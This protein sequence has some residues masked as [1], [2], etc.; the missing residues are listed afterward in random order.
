MASASENL[1]VRQHERIE[2]Q[3]AGGVR[4]AP[5]QNQAIRIASNVVDA[6]NCVP[7]SVRDCSMGGVGLHTGVFLPKRSQLTLVLA[8]GTDPDQ[9][10]ALDLKVMRVVMLD[11][12]P[13]YYLGAALVR[14][15]DEASR[16]MLERLVS[17][18]R[19]QAQARTAVLQ[20]GTPLA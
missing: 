4:V 5:A 8:I 13:T 2:C 18:A 19:A 14:P 12:T 17:L 16:A 7:A 6:S 3:F 15:D 10:F 11:R 20:G 1:V 9:S